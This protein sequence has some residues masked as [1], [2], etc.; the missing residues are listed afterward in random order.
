MTVGDNT[1]EKRGRTMDQ[2][3]TTSAQ[4]DA[5]AT[6]TPPAVS[7]GRDVAGTFVVLL[8]IGA[9]LT[10]LFAAL[11][12]GWGLWDFRAALSVILFAGIASGATVLIAIAIVLIARRRSRPVRWL[13]LGIGTILAAAFFVYFA[14]FLF[15]AVTLPGI[16]DVSTD[17]ADPP[18][19]A[20]LPLRAD[21]DLA[22][23][24]AEDAGM[25]GLTPRQRWA[26]I[27]QESYGDI[28]ALRVAAPVPQTLT[29]IEAL[30][31]ERG[32]EIA[33][34]DRAN[35]RIEATDTSTFFRFKDDVVVRVRPAEGGSASIVDMRSVSRVG[36]HDFGVN[37]NRVRAFLAD[38]P[39]GQPQAR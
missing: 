20:A 38:V 5:E 28:R 34:I 8:G 31:R 29:R 13:R 18:S 6:P 11:G 21:N 14:R 35:G 1:N 36:Q 32:W 4:P 39:A 25:R 3:Q 27:H 7:H 30:I 37:A 15:L 17:L 9:I 2:Q 16:H 26:A 23:P 19:F 22:V 10:A 24:G 12:T 33:A